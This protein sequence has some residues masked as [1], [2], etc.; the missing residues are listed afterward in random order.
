MTARHKLLILSVTAVLV[1]AV[2]IV[3]DIWQAS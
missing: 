3:I 2:L 1:M